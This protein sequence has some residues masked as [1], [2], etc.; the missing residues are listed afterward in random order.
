[1]IAVVD[2]SAFLRLFLPDG[3]LP[4]GLEHF[5]RAVE[6]GEN[7]AIAPELMLAESANVLNKKRREGLLSAGEVAELV[8]IVREMPIRYLPHRELI[9]GAV[10]L[11][12]TCGLTV[13]DALYLE[14]ARQKSAR[15]FTAD[16]RLVDAARQCGGAV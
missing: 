9:A 6:R 15:L 3:P 1:M 16:Q 5:L 13:Y 11:A 12:E 4:D 2:T 7:T 10:R 14:L 8:A